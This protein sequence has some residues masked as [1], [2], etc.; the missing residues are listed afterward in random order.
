MDAWSTD[1]CRRRRVAI[2]GLTLACLVAHAAAFEGLRGSR[3]K[4]VQDALD[5]AVPAPL[6][7]RTVPFEI[8][9]VSSAGVQVLAATSELTLAA[10][11]VRHAPAQ[12]TPPL[13]ASLPMPELIARVSLP[14]ILGAGTKSTAPDIRASHLPTKMLDVPPMPRSAPDEQL[15]EGFH[16]SGLPMKVRLYIEADGTV[17]ATELLSSAPGDED[18]ALQVMAM[19]RGTAFS[20]GRH[21]GI[22]A[23]S[24]IDIEIVLEPVLASLGRVIRQ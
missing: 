18:S 2:S 17:S 23:P 5:L 6:A 4:G 8:T 19:F 7:V 3:T 13:P 22:D 15:L 14:E 24:F 20:P 11:A 12:A 10:H 21:L 9:P 16:R 1:R